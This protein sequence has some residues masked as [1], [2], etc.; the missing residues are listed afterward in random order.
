[1]HISSLNV[2]GLHVPLK[3]RGFFQSLSKFS[4]SCLQETYIT[5]KT[6]QQWA[7]EWSGHFFYECGSSH[8]KGLIILVN[9]NFNVSN[10]N[11]IK[12]NDR[13]LGISFNL[14]DRHFVVF[15]V[16][17]PSKTHE[18]ISFINDL[19]NTLK[20][21]DYDDRTNIIIFGDFNSVMDNEMDILAGE[22]HPL[23]EV[24]CF[25]DFISSNGLH[26]VWRLKN[27]S[28]RDFSFIRIITNNGIND[29]EPSFSYVARRLDYIFCSS[30]LLNNLMSSSMLQTSLTDHKTVTTSFL[31]DNFPKGPGRW[32]F[33]ASLLDDDF[34][35]EHMNLFITNFLSD[36]K[37]DIY[38]DKRLTWDLLKVGI[39]DECI[40]F[41]RQKRLNSNKVFLETKIKEINQLLLT[42]QHDSPSH[43][44]KSL[45]DFTL[46]K[47]ILDLA[48]A[49]GPLKRSRAQFLDEYEKNTK[50][51]L[52]LEKGRQENVTIKSI[53]NQNKELIDNP[54]IILENISAFYINLLNEDNN[55]NA[56]ND[57]D[58][59]VLNNEERSQLDQPLEIN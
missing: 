7:K 2:R 33:N 44:L 34:F 29:Q 9:N 6:C 1:M 38:I 11:I 8:S 50:Y 19:T 36:I 55:D 37:K 18:R 23:R 42:N 39:R 25:N 5:D 17:S 46:K 20:L 13:C 54:D 21:N 32:Q 53:Y 47:E 43:I 51:F 26:D 35:I 59:P 58:H 57:I 14:S 12:I 3:R 30:N 16:Y 45:K 41:S 27:P 52:G 48:E 4:I 15:N 10:L 56:L 28:N 49:R 22:P 24:A 31:I 40:A